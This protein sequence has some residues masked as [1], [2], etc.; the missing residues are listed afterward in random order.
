MKKE[1]RPKTKESDTKNQTKRI[2]AADTK[3][4]RQAK[5]KR[6]KTSNQTIFNNEL[7]CSKNV[8]QT[9]HKRLWFTGER[10]AFRKSRL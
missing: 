8:A 7:S 6:N 10:Q 3:N 2:R 9:P 5:N 1:E 4:Q